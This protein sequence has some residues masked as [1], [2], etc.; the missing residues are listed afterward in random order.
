M[1]ILYGICITIPT[2]ISI[3][4]LILLDSI[5]IN[6]LLT[7]L[8]ASNA[9]M[10]I[11]I[12]FKNTQIFN[13]NNYSFDRFLT[14]IK[15]VYGYTWLS[16]PTLS[17]KYLL[18]VVARSIL[19]STKGE[20]AVAILTFASSL[21]SVF[22]SIE[23]GFFKAITPFFLLNDTKIL[24]KFNIAKKLILIQSIFTI[25][26]F[27]LSPY[28]IYI[29]KIIFQSKPEDVFVPIILIVMSVTTV[30][31]Y[32]KN[33]LLSKIK[34]HASLIRGFYLVSTIVNV[35]MIACITIVELSALKFV[36]IH[37]IFMLL[38]LILIR[39]IIYPKHDF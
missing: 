5:D 22:R 10:L 14:I 9:T 37:L 13:K 15:Y 8:S 31:S 33:Y 26:F 32:Y 19:L 28:W 1:T 11:Y 7:V 21:F 27:L 18:D 30:I 2:F 38:N 34:K 6:L 24:D 23:Q 4:I 35:L 36:I 3:P 12:I 39:L 20:L 17:A 25:L 16:V 29:L